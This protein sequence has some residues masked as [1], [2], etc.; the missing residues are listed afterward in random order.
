MENNSLRLMIVVSRAT[1]NMLLKN[2]F[3]CIKYDLKNIFYALKT[4]KKAL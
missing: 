4:K 2:C 1:K 3:K